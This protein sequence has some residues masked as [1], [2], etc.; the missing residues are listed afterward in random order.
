MQPG[1][2]KSLTSLHICA[3]WSELLLFARIPCMNPEDL[4]LDYMVSQTVF[5][6]LFCM[7][8]IMFVIRAEMTQQTL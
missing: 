7:I 4:Q 2:A 5:M 8:H 1:T 3:V 6:F